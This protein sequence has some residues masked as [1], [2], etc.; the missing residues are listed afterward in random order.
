MLPTDLVKW[1][2]AKMAADPHPV[3]VHALSRATAA[4]PSAQMEAFATWRL[5]WAS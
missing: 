1:R 2:P 3:G 4:F 5:D